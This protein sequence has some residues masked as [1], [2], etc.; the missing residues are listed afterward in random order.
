MRTRQAPY[1]A[2]M[3]GI[4]GV[5]V[6]GEHVDRELL[7]AMCDSLRHRGPDAAG[8]YVEGN[9]GLGIRRL[10]IIDLVTGDQ[11]L[12]NED[13]S[14]VLV[15]NGEIYNHVALRDDLEAQGHRFVTRTDGEVIVHLWE[16]HGADCVQRLRGMF[17]FAVWDARRQTL[18]L[19][20][21]RLG[22]KPLFYAQRRGSLRFAS[23]PQAILRDPGIS[24]EPDPSALDAFLVN[25][26]VPH[27]H[28]AFRHLR[29]LPPASTLVWRPGGEPMVTRY[30][31]LSYEPKTRLDLAEAA[32][33]L[34][35]EIL[36]AT[37]LRLG[38]DVPVGV[39][40][41]GGLDS[42]AVVAAM[43]MTSPGPVRTFSAVFPG[44]AVDEAPYADRVARRYATDHHE[45]D[46]APPDAEL[47]SR[48]AWH[49][50]E[51]FA[52]P[53]ALPTFQL[54]ELTRRHVTVALN[55]DGG[56]ESFAGY[57][58]YWQL[59]ATRPAEML[60]LGLRRAL[61]AGAQRLAGGAEGRAPLPRGARLA[62]RLALAP[63][64]RYSDL[65]RYFSDED[66]QRLY[67]PMLRESGER[68][69]PLD[70]VERAWAQT[71]QGDWL[72]RT[73]AVDLDTY[74]PDDLL[75]K[76]DLCSMAN[77]L[78]VRSPLLDHRLMEMAARLPRQQKLRGRTGKTLLREAVRPWLPSEIVD[79]PK[80]GFAVPIADW[81]RHELRSLPADILLDP[82]ARDR[83]VFEPA[84]VRR[85]IDEHQRG[86]D[87]STQLWAML[88]LELWFRTC[89]DPPYTR[90]ASRPVF[91]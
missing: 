71:S 3:C 48:I 65:F 29:K 64:R 43:A 55:G 41:S 2:P 85:V 45:L 23:E 17:A 6:H 51:P 32:D 50:G 88:N 31:R 22:K 42:S 30:W 13:G 12:S 82:R 24:R 34:R 26:Y 84:E 40:L 53:A 18:F 10:A 70:H 1:H 77:S 83:G 86:L 62:R 67:G 15:F 25:Q 61:A 27:H 20:R 52:D 87:R 89:V 4:A 69:D 11:P 80:H 46:V 76:V 49:F 72:D 56:D 37:R 28:C 5:V 60:P 58:R 8:M 14:V 54:C 47:L 9:V 36:E 39:L 35:H 63:P 68:S 21:D 78:E 66:R 75:V 57:R 79:R 19:A 91:A 74:L 81:L 73:M 16:D 7:E 38:S 59:A 44:R 90:A 33:A